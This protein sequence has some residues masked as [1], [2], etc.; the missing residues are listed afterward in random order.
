M[1]LVIVVGVDDSLGWGADMVIDMDVGLALGI[2]DEDERTRG[3]SCSCLY[4]MVALPVD[5]CNKGCH[6]AAGVDR[7]MG[8]GLCMSVAVED[9][10]NRF[11]G[12]H[13]S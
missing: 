13:H 11:I 7:G 9:A 5:R 3:S 12:L 1:E 2:M 6:G 4:W 8:L 10:E